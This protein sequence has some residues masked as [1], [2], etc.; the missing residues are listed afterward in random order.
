MEALNETALLGTAK[1]ALDL[2][3]LPEAVRQALEARPE[4]P[5]R[6]FLEVNAYLGFYNLAGRLPQKYTGTWN[7]QVIDEQKAIA[8]A[9]LLQLMSNFELI[10]YQLRESLL[11]AWLNVL[12]EQ[13]L[14]VNPGLVIRLIQQG[15]NLSNRTKAKI[16]EVIGNKGAWVL[17]YDPSLNYAVPAVGSAQWQDGTTQER[18]QLFAALRKTNPAESIEL[19]RSTW[20][21]EPIVSKKM[22]LEIIQQTST[23]SD[24]PFA[25]ELYNTEFQYRVKE[26]KTEKECRR[27]LTAMLLKYPSSALYLQT[28]DSLR[29][30]FTRAKKGI[31]N[32]VTQRENTAFNLPDQEDTFWSTAIMEQRYGL[33]AR[34]YDIAVYNTAM[35]FWLSYFLEYMPMEFW[36]GFFDGDYKRMLRYWLTESQYQTT[37]N[38]KKISIYASAAITNVQHHHDKK[39]AGVLAELLAPGTALPVLAVMDTADFEAYITKHQ[40]FADADQLSSG[41]Y[42]HEHSWSLRL[43][44][45]VIQAAYDLCLNNKTSAPLGKLIAQYAHHSSMAI[46]SSY[47]EKALQ[48]PSYKYWNTTIF[49]LAHPALEIRNKIYAYK[50]KT[51]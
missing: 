35:Q 14:I 45:K 49:Q 30:Y 29:H 33:D 42:T 36:A 28:A 46:L 9:D 31:L 48:T 50:T 15:R 47:N 21:T 3:L 13:K 20:A 38:G 51:P 22:F 11:N 16:V 26:K 40:Y 18:K 37:I 32:I 25:E 5:E 41:P 10:D 24:L 8:P 1:K 27:I 39:G 34:V 2:Q 6:E 23:L 4:D 12:I 17:Q 43:S 44:E 7:D 19:L